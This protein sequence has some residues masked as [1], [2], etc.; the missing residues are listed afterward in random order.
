MNTVYTEV[1][2]FLFQ[3]SVINLLIAVIVGRAFAEFIQSVV[4]DIIVPLLFSVSGKFEFKKLFYTI[5][6]S[7]ISYGETVNTLFTLLVTV[8][9]LYYIVIKPNQATIE[10]SDKKKEASTIKLI[11]KVV[12]EEKKPDVYADFGPVIPEETE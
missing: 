12:Q 2:E 8:L 9:T 6:S 1:K 7:K 5:G 4:S 10:K 11:K 3:G